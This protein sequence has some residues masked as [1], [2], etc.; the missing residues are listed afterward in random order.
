MLH[1]DKQQSFKQI[2]IKSSK[3]NNYCVKNFSVSVNQM[4]Q[5]QRIIAETKN[6]DEIKQN[7]TIEK[8]IQFLYFYLSC[9]N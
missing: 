5:T 8:I 9:E 4:I 3:Q 1:Q 2:S 7:K 6:A